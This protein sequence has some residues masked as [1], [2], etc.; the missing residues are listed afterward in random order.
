MNTFYEKQYDDFRCRKYYAGEKRLD[1]E[2]H[3]H[4][5]IEMVALAEGRTEAYADTERCMIEGGDIF[6]SFPN[7]IHRY[8]S[9]DN[10]RFYLLFVN[11]DLVPEL[12]EAFVTLR[13]TTALLKG[14][15]H[16]PDIYGLI[17]RLAREQEKDD[18]YATV[19]R[20]GY[21][22]SLF[23]LLLSRMELVENDSDDLHSL[24]ALVTYC[25]QNYTKDLSLTL[26]EEELHIS[27]YYISHLFSD[28]L[29]IGF[30]DY[31]NSLRV[32]LACRMLRHSEKSVTE[33]GS[34]SG[35]GTLRTFNRAFHKQMGCTPGE[36]R[37]RQKEETT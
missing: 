10:E 21:L 6:L 27:K 15:M 37:R 3:M 2:P 19:R 20:K 9:F 31:I 32:S 30:I 22:L 36:Y 23:S 35:F 11:P 18:D 12:A 8:I 33:I 14:A 1:K 29:G 26:L 16:D 24:K 7:A 13:P 5:H 34:E 4:Y 25:T 17:A 28:K